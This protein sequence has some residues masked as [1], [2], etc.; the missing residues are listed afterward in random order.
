MRRRKVNRS[1]FCR[2]VSMLVSRMRRIICFLLAPTLIVSVYWATHILL[3][4]EVLHAKA[5]LGRMRLALLR[6]HRQN[7]ERQP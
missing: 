7:F 3:R 5:L 6:L 2:V 1:R 4:A